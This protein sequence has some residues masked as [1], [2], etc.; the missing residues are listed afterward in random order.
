MG[1]RRWGSG[2]QQ[3]A[4]CLRG[5]CEP[6]RGRSDPRA[7]RPLTPPAGNSVRLPGGKTDA[8]AWASASWPWRFFTFCSPRR[9]RE[10]LPKKL[11]DRGGAFTGKGARRA[12]GVQ[13][14]GGGLLTEYE[15]PSLF[16]SDTPND[17]DTPACGEA[18]ASGT[19]LLLWARG[20]LMEALGLPERGHTAARWAVLGG[21]WR[22]VP[23]G[24]KNLTAA[25]VE[26]LT[27]SKTVSIRES[28]K[29][30]AVYEITGCILGDSHVY[31]LT[32]IKILH[33]SAL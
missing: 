16:V 11:C 31:I 12:L 18:W 23:F 30:P 6:R 7:P 26:V 20:I 24:G 9:Q 17:K 28:H 32:L 10:I 2:R 29:E 13:A 15:L 22:S 1:Q 33:L 4:S 19:R 27:P 5:G 14:G 3:S 21:R 25:Q 8:P